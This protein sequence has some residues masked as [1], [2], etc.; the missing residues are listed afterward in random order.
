MFSSSLAQSEITPI[1]TE[2]E[3]PQDEHSVCS[4]QISQLVHYFY[5]N[6]NG[7]MHTKKNTKHHS[8]SSQAALS[9]VIMC[10]YW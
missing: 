10:A 2:V 3:N 4:F 1:Y 7:Q 6:H 8:L 9:E 5:K